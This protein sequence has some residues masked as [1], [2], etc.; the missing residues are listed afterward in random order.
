[1]VVMQPCSDRSPVLGD[2]TTL[3]IVV[4]FVVVGVVVVV[5]VVAVADIALFSALL[6]YF[7]ALTRPQTEEELL[8]LTADARK[9][10]EEDADDGW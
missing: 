1:M 4:V 5:V 8:A 2:K 9:K 6:P 3:V 7:A 10:A